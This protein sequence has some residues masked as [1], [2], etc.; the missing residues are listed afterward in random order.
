M[1]TEFSF[2]PAGGQR[3][4][5]RAHRVL[6][7]ARLLLGTRGRLDE[8]VIQRLVRFGGKL[9]LSQPRFVKDLD[10]SA[11]RNRLGQVVDVDVIAE[12]LAGRAVRTFDRGSGIAAVGTAQGWSAK[13]L[14]WRTPSARKEESR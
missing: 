13:P 9:D 11:V 2:D 10:R 12:H 14:L 1:A 5:T 4:S 3:G 8:C 7:R 6:S